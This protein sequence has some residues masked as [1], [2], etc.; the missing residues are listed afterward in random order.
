MESE[1]NEHNAAVSKDRSYPRKD[2][3]E[4]SELLEWRTNAM[5]RYG[6]MIL[7]TTLLSCLFCTVSVALVLR[8]SF[9]LDLSG[10]SVFR[11]S[12]GLLLYDV[13]YV[14]PLSAIT[15]SLMSVILVMRRDSLVRRGQ[16][17]VDVLIEESERTDF[18]TKNSDSVGARIAIRSFNHLKT[19]PLSG[20]RSSGGLFAFISI[21]SSLVSIAAALFMI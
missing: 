20:E 14:F 5:Q 11:T 15:S 1:P 18:G 21:I 4:L 3:A 17:M 7:I 8:L 12:Q 9:S 16:V 19:M 10:E 6:S 2:I 13:F